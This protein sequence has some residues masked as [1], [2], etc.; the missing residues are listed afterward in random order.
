MKINL[1]A[2]T[3]AI[4]HS[5]KTEEA[6]QKGT[7]QDIKAGVAGA[8]DTFVHAAAD[9]SLAASNTK[10]PGVVSGL[11]IQNSQDSPA[12]HVEPGKA[13]NK[14]GQALDP[15]RN[16]YFDGK[17]LDQKDLSKD[18]EYLRNQGQGKTTPHRYL[19]GHASTAADLQREQDY[20]KGSRNPAITDAGLSAAASVFGGTRANEV[21]GRLSALT[22]KSSEEL[23]NLMN[24]YGLNAGNL[25]NPPDS[26]V[27]AFVHDPAFASYPEQALLKA[28]YG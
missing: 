10:G 3:T 27:A 24:K 12:V 22:G 2:T 13:F 25:P 15:S 19:K 16:S 6:P 4:D 18:Q 23:L 14:L 11:G 17:M 1:P 7:P 26:K 9:K 20:K 28:L 8:A 21:L 5:L